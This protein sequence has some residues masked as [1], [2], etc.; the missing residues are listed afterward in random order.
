MDEMNDTVPSAAEKI[1]DAIAGESE[2]W[3]GYQH[4]RE[5]AVEF[6]FPG[7]PSAFDYFCQLLGAALVGVLLG[8]TVIVVV[9]K[10]SELFMGEGEHE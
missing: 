4:G 5:Y 7:G 1:A 3:M 8:L 9:S 6:D 10:I 2:Y